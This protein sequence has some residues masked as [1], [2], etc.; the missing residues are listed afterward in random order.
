MGAVKDWSARRRRN[1]RLGKPLDD[2]DWDWDFLT[3]LLAGWFLA[4][5]YFYWIWAVSID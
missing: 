4:F 5:G 1:W 2:E 3:V